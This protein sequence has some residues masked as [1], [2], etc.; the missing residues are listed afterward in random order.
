[1]R[2]TRNESW[3]VDKWSDQ[4]DNRPGSKMLLRPRH[5]QRVRDKR[6]GAGPDRDE[7]GRTILRW[8]GFAGLSSDY[9][10]LPPSLFTFFYCSTY[11]VVFSGG[12][13][14][15]SRI[16]WSTRDTDAMSNCLDVCYVDKTCPDSYL[17]MKKSIFLL[18]LTIRRLD[19][20]QNDLWVT[21]FELSNNT[22]SLCC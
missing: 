14:H 11:Y 6:T 2:S 15:I 10:H 20:L 18:L 21:Y 9:V 8:A 19:K 12:S 5:Q 4:S 3:G 7:L 17:T 16:T 22:W 1:M 13:A